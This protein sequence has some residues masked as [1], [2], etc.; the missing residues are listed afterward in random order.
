MRDMLDQFFGAWSETDRIKQA[1]AI[2]HT[3]TADARYADPRTPEALIGPQAIAAYV[4]GF[5][6]MAPGAVADVVQ[7][8][9]RDGITRA[10]VAFV[11]PGGMRQMG[12]Y[13]VQTDGSGALARLV[14]FVGTG[15]PE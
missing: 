13:V 7:T 5:T 12:Q 10:T 1:D 3:L 14:G 2:S 11:M 15:A 8:D 6:E 4:A 9:T